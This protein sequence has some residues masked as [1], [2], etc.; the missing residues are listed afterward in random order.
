MSTADAALAKKAAK[1][2]ASP[3]AATT[4]AGVKKLPAQ[5]RS[6]ADQIERLG[7]LLNATSLKSDWKKLTDAAERLSNLEAA[8][9]LAPLEDYLAC[10]HG[11]LE[12]WS[13]QAEAMTAFCKQALGAKS[14][15]LPA[16]AGEDRTDHQLRLLGLC[17]GS[18]GRDAVLKGI[19]DAQKPVEREV[20]PPKLV[21]DSEARD[22]LHQWGA[23]P[24]KEFLALASSID[25]DL[26]KRGG[27]LLGI[28]SKGKPT[29]GALKKIHKAAAQF[30]RNTRV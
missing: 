27:T 12:A 13:K 21:A 4:L 5:L 19:A 8:D 18:A 10:R 22:A 24:E 20:T 15:A 28:T 17:L 25:Q 1:A 11:W 26:L 6:L 23:M 3:A 2:P 16:L 14:K 29:A 30:H 7:P 9:V